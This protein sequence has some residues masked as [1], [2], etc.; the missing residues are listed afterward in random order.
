MAAYGIDV[1]DPAVSPRR[2]WVLVNRLPPWARTP[3]EDWSTEAS[4]L[5]V[6]SDQIADLTWLVAQL[7]GSKSARP[8][9]LPRP[10]P[11]AQ[12]RPEPGVQAEAEQPSGWLSQLTGLAGVVVRSG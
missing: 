5:A 1:L 12:R 11:R 7:G 3:G 10:V 4:L 8:T 6:L 2:V 9:P